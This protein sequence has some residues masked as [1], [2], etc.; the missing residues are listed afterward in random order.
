MKTVLNL[1]QEAPAFPGG[2]TAVSR[3]Q[4]VKHLAKLYDLIVPKLTLTPPRIAF[5]RGLM[6]LKDTDARAK[7]ERLAVL[8][9]IDKVGPVVASKSPVMTTTE[10]GDAIGY[11][12]C[13]VA[14]VTHTPST[15]FSPYLK[16]DN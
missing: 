10:F 13:R 8:G 5:D 12:L 15:K 7:A 6:T 2:K 11:F 4:V 16:G 3:E 1:G 9:F 14:E